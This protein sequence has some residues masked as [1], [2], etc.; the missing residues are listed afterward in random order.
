METYACSMCGHIYD[1]AKGEPKSFSK[2]LCDSGKGP[3]TADAVGE[4]AP[5]VKPGTPFSAL[6]PSWVCP[7]C[8]NLKSYFRVQREERL[9]SIRTIQ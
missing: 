3:C 8:G 4:V 9:K 1:P 7:V 6:P 2:I 5:Y